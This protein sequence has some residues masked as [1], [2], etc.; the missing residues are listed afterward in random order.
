MK[1]SPV[2][3]AIALTACALPPPP[4][5]VSP[6]TPPARTTTPAPT[7]LLV[8]TASPAPTLETVPEHRIGVRVVDGTGEFYDRQTGERFVPRGNNYIRLARQA[9]G[10][11]FTFY[12]STFNTDFY[13]PERAEA[14]LRR[15]S[16]EGY[17]VVRVFLNNCCPGGM[18]GGTD[19]LSPGYF[20]NVVDFLGRARANGLYVM[21]AQDWLPDGMYGDLIGAECCET[22]D[23]NNVLLLSAGGLR[24]NQLFFQEFIGALIERRAPLDAILAYA[25]RNEMYF[26]A[27]EPP[28]SLTAG[29]VTTANGETYDMAVPE[30]KTRMTDE[31]L[32]YFIDRVRAAILEVDPTALVGVGFFHPQTPHPTRLGDPRF[33]ETRPAIWDSSADFIDLHAYPGGELNLRQL[34]ENYKME[35]MEVR[36]ILM[37]EFGAFRFAYRSVDDAARALVELQ[38]E[39]CGYGFD[40]WL[41]WTW[42]TDEQPEL[43]NGLSEAGQINAAL[44]P[45]NRPDPCAFGEATPRNLALGV[46]VTASRWLPTERPE[47][48]ADGLAGTQWGAGAHPPQW[49][50]IDLGVPA[51][52]SEIWLLAAQFP[53]GETVHRISARGLGGEYQTL[54]E[55]RGVTRDGD[56]L[57]YSLQTPLE[58]LQLVRIETLLSPSWVSWRE[59]EVIGTGGE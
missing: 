52:I 50:E 22:F 1:S 2:L 31:G 32:V 54:T 42:D 46:A 39:S 16:A 5:T 29:R 43:Y 11:G 30:D 53:E 35:G 44:A 12:H 3:V 37:G 33:I 13:E 49:I 9:E 7:E 24:A 18:S 23:V 41:L 15:M 59:V 14:S 25:L 4:A 48:A 27:N 8:P 20:D 40:G 28:L 34:V 21:F 51:T 36:P 47:L 56:W 45:V 26:D 10:S 6:A 55:L 58:G 17:N 19:R 57:V 38:V